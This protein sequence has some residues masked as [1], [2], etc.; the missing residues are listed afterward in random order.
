MKLQQILKIAVRGGAS[1]ILLK[2]GSIPKFRHNGILIP[3]SDGRPV[4]P[5]IMADWVSEILPERL[6][7]KLQQSG[8]VDFGHESAFASSR[9]R[10][11]IFKQ[12]GTYAII[13]R[14]ILD[15]IRSIGDSG[16]PKAIQSAAD[17]RRGLVLVTGAT[18]SG[19]STTLAGII[20]QINLTREVHV[21]TIEDPIEFYYTEEKATISQREIG[22]DTKNFSTALK[23]SLR[24]DPDIIMVGELRDRETIETAIMAAETGHLVFSTLHTKDAADSLT[25][26]MSYFPPHQHK[27]I[28]MQLSES[29]KMVASQ[30][31]IPR[32]DG[33]GRI[34]AVEV[35]VVNSLA[36]EVLLKEENFE[37][38]KDVIAKGTQAYGMQSFDQDLFS[39][40]Q[41]GLIS[42]D[43]AIS[44]ATSRENMALQINGVR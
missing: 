6:W 37:R 3:L 20:Q 25:R 36:R 19:K 9:F 22:E 23:D 38:L 43:Q 11:N 29:L 1:D 12:K 30:R 2:V 27:S 8:S 39:M 15:T 16:L 42:K 17:Y 18:G 24:Q 26:I 7:D 10:V 40:Y 31:L 33:K 44:E 28:R 35:L 4:S 34:A 32:K 41:A 13:M 14:V 21:I 5:Q